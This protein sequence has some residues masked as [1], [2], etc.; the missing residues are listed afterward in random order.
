MWVR[1]PRMVM[2]SK[3]NNRGKMPLLNK[4]RTL[5]NKN[6]IIKFLTIL[7]VLFV[8][9]NIS[10]EYLGDIY[11]I[12]LYRIIFKQKCFGCGTKR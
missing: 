4:I 6:G 11:S 2:L 10:R 3:R 12:C 7:M 5:G 9:Y 1:E 8:F